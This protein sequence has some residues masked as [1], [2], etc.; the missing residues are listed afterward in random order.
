MVDEIVVGFEDAVREPV[1]AQELPHVFDWVELG[2]FGRQCHDGDIG[3]HD[4]ARGQMPAGLV[5]QEDGVGRRRDSFGDLGEVQIHCLSV[6]GRQDQGRAL[7]LV[8]ADRAEDVGRSGALI[9]WGDRTSAALGPSAGDLVLLTNAGL[10]G[11]P[12][13]YGLAVERLL[14]RDRLQT[15][16]EAFLK[17]SI[18]LAA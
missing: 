5:D 9:A 14:A 11:E 6:A 7:A 18:A 3:R 16:G 1:I 17:S 13:F 10:V 15:G 4:E 2:A 8:R 12:D